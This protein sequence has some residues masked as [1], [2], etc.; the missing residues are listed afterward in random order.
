L[1]KTGPSKPGEARTGHPYFTHDMILDQP[2]CLQSTLLT[3][4][5]EAPDI[6]S[7][8]AG[9]NQFVLTGCGT[10]YHAALASSYLL[11]AIFQKT[12]A[13]SVE[14]FELTYYFRRLNTKTI[15]VGFSHTGNTKTTLDAMRV[16]KESGAATLGLT[17]TR[18]SK[19][20]EIADRVLMVGNGEEKS[21]AHT[22]SYTASVLASMYLSLDF[23]ANEAS[24]KVAEGLL[25]Q[26]NDVP[27]AVGD[28]LK[29]EKEISDFV[30]KL[31]NLEDDGGKQE[32]KRYFFVGAGP[33]IATALEAALKIKETS[34]AC[35][36]GMELEQFLHGPW[37]S[38]DSDALVVMI[39][40]KGPAHQRYLDL[41]QVCRELGVKTLAI[42]DDKH[43]KEL[44]SVSIE[45]KE[46]SEELSPLTYI[47]PLQL[48]AYH[49][50]IDKG[51]N[52]DLIR[53][54]NSKIWGARQIIFPPG[55]H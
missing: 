51:L 41:L 36:E 54:D 39:A 12:S 35:A 29:S 16:A 52:P 32:I 14:S 1:E 11:Y 49:I 28:A 7:Y 42:T 22:K 20:F 6:R 48:L 9:M 44:A 4:K 19:I 53:Y 31:N 8:Y 34:Y 3:C 40:P 55:T 25:D 24:N 46:L 26:L 23:I 43:V 45:M 21:R 27:S 37:V 38:L 17:G 50:A 10:S 5:A 15:V 47:V 18:G 33:N 13:V 2:S 30:R